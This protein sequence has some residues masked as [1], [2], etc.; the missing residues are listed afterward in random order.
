MKLKITDRILTAVAG[1][2]ILACGAGVFMQLYLDV[3]LISFAD[4]VFSSSTEWVRICLTLISVFLLF[5]GVCCISVSC[6]HYTK[7][8]RFILQKNEGGELAISV[9]AMENMVRK[10][11]DQHDELQV[12]SLDLENR[13]D[14]LLIHI[15]GDVAGGISIP[16]TVEALQK[17][18]RQYVTACSGVEVKSIR[19]QIESSGEDAENAPF[20]IA[21][22]SMAPLLHGPEE[23]PVQTAAENQ[24]TEPQ[25]KSADI[26]ETE[27]VKKE[28]VRPE[29]VQI[30]PEEDDDDERPLHQRLFSL[31]PEPCIVPEPPEEDDNSPSYGADSPAGENTEE[32][33]S[34]E[35]TDA[36]LPGTADEGNPETIID[37]EEQI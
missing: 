17:Q 22:P 18:I 16:L 3:D 21:P 9:Q 4:R 24:E 25:Q 31:K 34:A 26:T 35:E 37:E 12:E 8:D 11:L 36:E 1:L 27:T 29:T 6:R 30:V 5:L 10:C 20:A 28:A 32:S 23:K 7:K 33:Y 13:K 2:L 15:R 19:V 14:G